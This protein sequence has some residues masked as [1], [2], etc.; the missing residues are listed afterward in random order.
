MFWN[1]KWI[2]R[3]ETHLCHLLRYK[4]WIHRLHMLMLLMLLWR[5]SRGH[6][7]VSVLLKR[8]LNHYII[9]LEE[10]TSIR[11]SVSMKRSMIAH[12]TQ[13]SPAGNTVLAAILGPCVLQVSDLHTADHPGDVKTHQTKWP[14]SICLCSSSGALVPFDGAISGGQGS[15]GEPWLVCS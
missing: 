5:P 3:S 8:F 1:S 13:S 7:L 6:K 10:A 14:S 15:S 4:N 12:T 2:Y 9:L 11:D